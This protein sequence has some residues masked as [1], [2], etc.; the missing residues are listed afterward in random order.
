[1]HRGR[2]R[3]TWSITWC[4]R[5]CW[6]VCIAPKTPAAADLWLLFS[7]C[8]NLTTLWHSFFPSLPLSP[9]S[10]S[11][12]SQSP[13]DNTHTHTYFLMSST[14]AVYFIPCSM[15]ATATSTGALAT[16]ASHTVHSN[17]PIRVVTKRLLYHVKSVLNDLCW[18]GSTIFKETVL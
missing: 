3:V 14:A 17:T 1:M 4:S 9:F 13:H 15:S 2:W 10:L 5:V 8:R 11:P 16:K 18:R 7:S 6:Q 12:F